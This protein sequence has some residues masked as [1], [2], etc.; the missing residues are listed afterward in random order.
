MALSTLQHH[1][2]RG[3]V[4]R[5]PDGRVDVDLARQQLA[6]RRDPIQSMRRRQGRPLP[7]ATA[8]DAAGAVAD[9]D[10]P[11]G[12]ALWV[13]KLRTEAVRRQLLEMEL[14]ERRSELLK[15]ADVEGAIAA[16]IVATREALLSVADREAPIIAAESD[17]GVVHRRLRQAI[18]DALRMLCVQAPAGP[19]N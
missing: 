10:A 8:G 19:L 4:T 18:V 3:T 14:A 5:G 12:S 16:K 2:H 6:H 11:E 7:S 13:E 17:Q 1:I 15:R 9:D